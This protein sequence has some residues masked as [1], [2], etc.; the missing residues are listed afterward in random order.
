M[1]EYKGFFIEYNIYGLKE[2]SVQYCGDD[3]VFQTEDEA[4]R[5]IDMEVGS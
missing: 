1:T 5:F 2:Y 4:K 3:Y